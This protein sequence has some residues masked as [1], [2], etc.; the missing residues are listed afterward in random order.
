MVV[1]WQEVKIRRTAHLL[2]T[3]ETK[4][5]TADKTPPRPTIAKLAGNGEFGVV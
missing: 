3:K 4:A 1:E 5:A 2:S